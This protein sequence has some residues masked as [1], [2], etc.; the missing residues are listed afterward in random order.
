MNYLCSV[1]SVSEVL[2]QT[3][4]EVEEVFVSAALNLSS[5]P[6]TAAANNTHLFN[7]ATNENMLSQ[8]ACQIQQKHR[9]IITDSLMQTADD[10]INLV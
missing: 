9:N 5:A 3:V 7:N 6:C 8:T 10:I 2:Y 1:S 4:S